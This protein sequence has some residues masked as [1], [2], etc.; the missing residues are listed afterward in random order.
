MSKI[1]ELGQG[2]LKAF[3]AFIRRAWS[4]AGPEAPGWTGATDE[5]VLHLASED[6]LASLIEDDGIS[7]FVAW[8]EG[9]PVGF[10]SNRRVDDETIELSGIVVLESMTGKGV[11]SQLLEA[12]RKAALEN[13]YKRMIMKTEAYNN[14]AIRFYT[15]KGFKE[16]RKSM[17]EIEGIKI[18]LVELELPLVAK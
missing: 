2:D 15:G 1:R 4:E 17:A 3:G 16:L 7:I 14:R 11:G 6:Y 9:E 12:A 18:E 10:S 13:T 5:G 8:D